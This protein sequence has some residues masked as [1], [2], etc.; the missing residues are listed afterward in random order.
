MQTVRQTN[1]WGG[2]DWQFTSLWTSRLSLNTNNVSSLDSGVQVIEVSTS[3][4]SK[5]G[6]Q[7]NF[8]W[9][10]LKIKEDEFSTWWSY[11]HNTTSDFHSLIFNEHAFFN[12]FCVE[13]FAEFVYLMSAV[14][15]MRVGVNLLISLWLKPVFSVFSVL[16]WVK[17][18]LN[19]CNLSY[20]FRLFSIF[21]SLYFFLLSKF[22]ILFS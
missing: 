10:T 7:L 8:S 19:Y 1:D 3:V 2:S 16:S 22:C 21:S 12:C 5:C 20:L 4:V 17:F 13:F 9:I 6:H 15:L 11:C 18:F 14:E